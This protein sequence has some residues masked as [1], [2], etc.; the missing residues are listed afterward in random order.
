MESLLLL[1]EQ[2]RWLF[3]LLLPII[4]V[5]IAVRLAYRSMLETAVTKTEKL[6]KESEDLAK[7]ALEKEA[8][9]SALETQINIHKNFEVPLD[10]HMNID[11]KK[12]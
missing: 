3:W 12:D 9:I 4:L 7:K 8:E 1:W 10:W 11:R 6:N 2:R 5:A